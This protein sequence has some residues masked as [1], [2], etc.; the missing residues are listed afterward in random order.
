MP[1]GTSSNV[2]SPTIGGF[3]LLKTSLKDCVIFD[4][5]QLTFHLTM[6]I[7]EK[8]ARTVRTMSSARLASPLRMTLKK[9]PMSGF[10]RFCMK[11]S[12]LFRN[13]S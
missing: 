11:S 12:E 13:S 4:A 1:I 3:V 9:P 7:V 2:V 6:F 5:M 8:R 10:A